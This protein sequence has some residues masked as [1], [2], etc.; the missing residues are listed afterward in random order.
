MNKNNNTVV[1]V[2]LVI[3]FFAIGAAVLSCTKD[4]GEIKKQLKVGI[5]AI[6]VCVVGIVII[7][8]IRNKTGFDP[9]G[10]T[11]IKSKFLGNLFG[12]K[13]E[14]SWW[15]ISHFLLY[16]F[17]GIFAPSLWLLWFTLGIVWEICEALTG[18]LISKGRSRLGKMYRQYGAEWVCGKS[19]DIF[20][21][22]VGL[23]TGV[24]I[25]SVI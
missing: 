15:P 17:L 12:E 21:N 23:L 8:L 20:F 4:R 13:E 19:S 16:L 1:C 11:A 6:V 9:F 22:S 2:V 14:F 25:S 10:K 5:V 7:G 18:K 24:L 3:I